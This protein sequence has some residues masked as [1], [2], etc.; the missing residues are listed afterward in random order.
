MS[1]D[2]PADPD[3]LRALAAS[4]RAELKARD[5]IIE[6]LKAQLAAL[7]RARFGR[8]SEK[9][10][11]EIEQ[12]ELVLGDLEE[13]QG[14]RAERAGQRPPPEPLE[15]PRRAPLPPHLPRE[16][17]RHEP[18]AACPACGGTRFSC[19]SQDEREVLEYVPAHFKV[20]VHVRPKFSCR[21]CETIR[22]APMP[23]LPIERGLAGPGLLAH[24][25]VSKYADHLPLYRQSEIFERGGVDLDRSTLAGW[26]GQLGVILEPLAEAIGAHAR[27]GAAIHADD[28]PVP[29][30]DPGRGKTKTGRLWALVRDERPWTGP[31]PPAAYYLYSP[32]RRGEHAERLLASCRGFLHAD[33]YAGFNTL[34]ALQPESGVPRLTEVACWAHARRKLYEVHQATGSA[35]AQ[36]ALERIGELF[37]IEAQINGRPPEV[38]LAQ[39]QARTVPLLGELEA[40]LD[41][42]LAGVSRKSSLAGAIRYATSRWQALARFTT[43]GRLEM[44]NNAAERAIRPLALGRKNY[45]FAGSDAGGRRAAILYTLIGTA[46]LNGLDPQA[47]LTDAIARIADHPASR[48]DELLPWNWAADD[49]RRAA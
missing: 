20:V 38:R 11:R 33:G 24:V 14:A 43:D 4:L 25:A 18:A 49:H 31:A 26:I 21:T 17:V 7:R 13:G 5:L 44:T 36:E 19:I 9:L 37:A 40:F 16:T 10:E 34:Y 23:A 35:A 30:L 3:A 15:R 47:W 29:V 1:S 41:R 42:T 22:Q 6:Q 46:K 8:S 39:R 48:I 12:L 32:D 27:A 2:L 28:T 45:L